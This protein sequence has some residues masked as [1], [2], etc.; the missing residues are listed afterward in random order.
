MGAP[1]SRVS[2][3]TSAFGGVELDEQAGQDAD[4]LGV[5]VGHEGGEA[6]Q[7]DGDEPVQL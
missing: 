6:V 7:A 5:P 4:L 3:P 2:R 1:F